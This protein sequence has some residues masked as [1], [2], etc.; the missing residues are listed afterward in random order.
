M[1]SLVKTL[2]ASWYTSSSLY[3]LEKRAVFLKSWYFLGPVTR[4]VDEERV[5][6]EIAQV[7]LTVINS[8][9]GQKAT[10]GGPYDHLSVLQTV[11]GNETPMRHHVT[12]SGLLFVALSPSTP[13]FST[14]FPGIEALISRVDFTSLPYRHSMSYPGNFNWKTM[15]DGYQECLHCQYTHPSFSKFYPPTFYAVHNHENFSQHIA[16]PT[17]PEDGLFLYFFPNCTLNVYGGGMSSF[18]VCPT[19]EPGMARMEFDYYHLNDGGEFDEYFKFVR[20]VAEEDFELCEKAQGNLERGIYERGILNPVKETGVICEFA[21]SFH[22]F[23]ASSLSSLSSFTS[24]IP[25][26]GTRII[27]VRYFLQWL[28][29]SSLQLF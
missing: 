25:S 28:Q 3:Q 12:T 8:Q 14:Y 4:F 26:L 6:Y 23:L 16:D 24:T 20:K 15:V 10:R 17:K 1:A 29:T 5:Q 22:P 13:S 19:E 27:F 18:R 2:P 9:P 7:N 11:S 21:R